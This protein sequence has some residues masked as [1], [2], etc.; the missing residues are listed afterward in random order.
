MADIGDVDLQQVI[1]AGQELDMDGVIEIASRFAVNSDHIR[2]TKI[3]AAGQVRFDNLRRGGGSLGESF[4][5]Y[6]Y[7]C[8]ATYSCPPSNGCPSNGCP[9][10]T[11]PAT[12]TCPSGTCPAK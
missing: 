7:Q 5:C 1:S 2:A 4:S 3:A 6:T 9:S 12:Y 8:G 10:N 11:C